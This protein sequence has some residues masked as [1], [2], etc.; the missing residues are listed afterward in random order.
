[1][2]EF[3]FEGEP[4]IVEPTIFDLSSPGRTGVTFPDLDVPLAELPESPIRSR[5]SSLVDRLSLPSDEALRL[6]LPA[7][8]RP[9]SGAAKLAE[10]LRQPLDREGYMQ[11]GQVRGRPVGSSRKGLYFVGGCHGDCNPRQAALEAEAV[12]AEVQRPQSL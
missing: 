2:T 8:V 6:V 7:K 5:G 10:V 1:M 3:I 12:T 4:K 11:P 9:A